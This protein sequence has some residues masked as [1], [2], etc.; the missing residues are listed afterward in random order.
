MKF[1]KFLIFLG[2]LLTVFGIS[3]VY[4]G[5]AKAASIPSTG[6]AKLSG[7][8]ID[9]GYAGNVAPG[10][11]SDGINTSENML[12]GDIYGNNTINGRI[13][14]KTTQL[15]VAY[16]LGLMGKPM[17]LKNGHNFLSVYADV[18]KTTGA[19]TS[20]DVSSA[21]STKTPNIATNVASVTAPSGYQLINVDFSDLGTK[22]RLPVLVGY[23][24]TADDYGT[25]ITVPRAFVTLKADTTAEAS[26][27]PVKVT[28]TANADGN[29]TIKTA[30]ST[31][32]GTAEK[33]AVISVPVLS[34]D[35]TSKT[36]STT[37]DSDGNFSIS[38]GGGL[39]NV[40]DGS[41]LT[42]TETN[43][44]GDSKTGTAY[45]QAKQP[46]VIDATN[47]SLDI[48]PADVEA[49]GTTNDSVYAWLVSHAGMNVTQ[50][51]KAITEDTDGLKYTSDDTN[52]AKTIGSL[53]NGAS[54][55]LSVGATDT[56]GDK[57]NS[58]VAIKLTKND[59]ELK[60]GAISQGMDFGSQAVPMKE[61]LIAPKGLSVNVQDTR[62]ASS[63]WSVS[64]NA[65]TLTDGN[66]HTL[67]GKLV[68]LDSN[69]NKYQMTDQDITV[70]TGA[71]QSGSNS[72]D[73]A[74]KWA[75][76]TDTAGKAGIFLDATPNIYSGTTS[77]TYTGEVT[78]SLT[79]APGTVGQSS[80]TGQ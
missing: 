71:R 40:A 17:T 63:D 24:Y 29:P 25:V 44:F 61:T 16:T 65:S 21:A 9:T 5:T 70:A 55:T 38:V 31:I 30:D 12:V 6:F 58:N 75:T 64:A 77:T 2:L 51:S 48:T 36:Y 62:V 73:I 46:L 41:K 69:G 32:T 33:N 72:F 49:M 26:M 1:R 34:T 27:A 60:F 8:T 20:D 52:L 23:T 22:S 11:D 14:R 19:G 66:G 47:K 28:A 59:G 68:Y 39:K 43:D 15:Y 79:N 67:A 80:V 3:F 13:T 18:L 76:S 57:T 10:W 35:G 50:D 42:F 78:W 54:T 7:S 4:T 45:V 74:G 37:A 56:A 53:A